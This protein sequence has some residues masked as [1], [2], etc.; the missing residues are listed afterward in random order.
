MDSLGL[1][2][3]LKNCGY[4]HAD[5]GR[6]VRA[7]GAFVRALKTLDGSPATQD[8]RRLRVRV[9]L[10]LALVCADLDNVA[11]GLRALEQAREVARTCDDETLTTV[12]ESQHGLLLI[13]AGLPSEALLHLNLAVKT[14]DDLDVVNRTSVLLNRGLTLLDLNEVAL[15]TADFHRCL[16]LPG[17]EEHPEL[18]FKARCNLGW[19]EFLAG[20][21]PAALRAMADAAE[22]A[23]DVE[24]GILTMDRARVLTEAGLV[25]EADAQLALA[26]AEFTRLRLSQDRGEAEL[27]RAECALL[28]GEPE[29]AEQFARRA[30]ARFDRRGS[31]RWAQQ[32]RLRALHARAGVH[33]DRRLFDEAL[34]LGMCLADQGQLADAKSA[35]LLAAELAVARDDFLQAQQLIG[36]PSATD[37]IGLRTQRCLVAAKV[38]LAQ[39]RPAVARREIARGLADIAGHQARFG[40]LD[41]RTAAAVHGVRLTQLHLDTALLDGRARVVFQAGEDVRAISSRLPFVRAPADARTAELLCELRALS[42]SLRG[43]AHDATPGQ[44]VRRCELETQIAALGWEQRGSTA[45]SGRPV[46]YAAARAALAEAGTDLVAYLRTGARLFAIVVGAG[47][48]RVVQVGRTEDVLQ[49]VRRIRADLDLLA[50]AD[51]PEGIRDVARRSLSGE[52]AALDR[53]IL[54]PLA[55]G[56]RPLT[57]VAGGAAA[58]VPWGM[59]PALSGVPVTLTPSATSWV[60]APLGL[61]SDPIVAALAGPGL[62]RAVQEARTVSN[63]WA[64]AVTTEDATTSLLLENL[65]TA[66]LVHVAAH[67]RHEAQNPMFSSVRMS[68]GA[69]FAHELP[70]LRQVPRHVVL[71]ACDVGAA[72]IRPGDEP[73]GLTS[74]LLHAGVRS[75]VASVARVADD[76]AAD[77]MDRYHHALQI[78]RDPASALA[79]AVAEFDAPAPFVCFGRS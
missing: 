28:A 67:G 54:T 56:C 53:Q 64:Q 36:Q 34:E 50:R 78:G 66:D 79:K 20:D 4:D 1:A 62:E 47:R 57:V 7:R 58:L 10:G 43:P 2:E 8:C 45:G 30:A 27:A 25:R 65:G 5:A 46:A 16:A 26:E 72:T 41:L 18:L 31:K 74:V 68:D 51:L 55:V 35:R 75:V 63:I 33:P 12:V 52:L 17:V 76:V 22:M 59:L 13:R 69:L 24:R 71:S 32:A 61:P 48:G 70:A 40:G 3:S 39:E 44:L 6:P 73:L 38:A 29:R 23:V 14:M 19:A 9:M 49:L 11:A 21:L 77:T 60:N 37:R 15:A 42:E